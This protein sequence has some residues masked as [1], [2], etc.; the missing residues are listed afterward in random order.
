MNLN[1][2]SFPEVTLLVTHYN[3]IRSLER[4]LQTFKDQQFSFGGIVVSDD[5]SKPEHLERLRELSSVYDYQLVTTPVNKGLGNNINKGQ[6]AVA[7][8]YTLYVQEDFEPKPEFVEHFKDAL[9]FMEQDPSLD[10]ARF[11]AY[12][13]YPYTKP[14]GKGFVQMIFRPQLWANN[15][16]KFYVYSDHPHLRRTTFFN[17]FGRYAEGVKGDITEYRMARSF[18][19]NK[20]KGIFF[21][22][23]TDLFYQKNSSDEPSTMDRANWRESRNPLM[24]TLRFFYL[25]LK[26]ARWTYDVLYK[27]DK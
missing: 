3:R 7:T 18:I 16:L 11:Y 10:I 6:D 1:V 23:F 17:K 15:H 27:K 12:F 13:S 2:N 14:Y 8:P 9:T 22:R 26:L 5:G 21:E 25:Q 19:R 20:G 4:L 24:L